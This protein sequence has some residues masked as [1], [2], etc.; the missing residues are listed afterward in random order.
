MVVLPLPVGPVTTTRPCGRTSQRSKRV[1][2]VGQEPELGEIADEHARIEHAHHDLVAERGRDRRDAELHLRLS[3]RRADAP[4]LRPLQRDVEAAH[5]LEAVRDRAVDRLGDAVDRVEHA[6]DPH[7]DDRLLA[8]RLEVD[9]AGAL[10]ERVVKQV[11]HRG[12]D[13]LGGCLERLDAGEVHELLEVRDVRPVR[14]LL[15][16]GAR[17]GDLLAEPVDLGDGS[18]D[19]RGRGEDRLD[20]GAGEAAQVLEQLAIERVRCRD[21]QRPVPPLE[22]EHRV[23]PRERARQR[24][25]DEVR[26]ELQRVDLPVRD[27]D[28]LR[29]RLR[30]LVLVDELRVSARVGE[31]ERGEHLDGRELRPSQPAAARARGMI[32]QQAGALDVLAREGRAFG[33]VGEDPLAGEEIGHELEGV[34]GRAVGPWHGAREC[35]AG[36]PRSEVRGIRDVCRC[37]SP[38]RATC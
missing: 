4:V 20:L 17:L 36:S 35:T 37:G 13:R 1:A 31:L 8:P 12:D 38:D 5:D 25:R 16:L 15:E 30:H 33:V 29:D 14:A 3:A 23:P 26:V 9:V 24:P 32:A 21:D 2:L 27:P 11:L 6:V 28:G 22:G 18:M 19:V 10:L 7:A 34:V